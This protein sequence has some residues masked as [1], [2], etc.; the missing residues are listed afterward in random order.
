MGDREAA[1]MQFGEER[2]DVAQDGLAR[3]GVA[4]MADGLRCP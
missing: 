2:L 1:A 4:D 3:G